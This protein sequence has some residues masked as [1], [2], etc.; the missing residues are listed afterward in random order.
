MTLN[1]SFFVLKYVPIL[2]STYQE[3]RPIT[4][5]IIMRVRI[6]NPK[7]VQYLQLPQNLNGLSA[8]S[9]FANLSFE[10]GSN[11]TE[12]VQLDSFCIDTVRLP[13]SF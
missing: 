12:I 9:L 7:N 6:E 4:Y 13:L 11:L 8:T 1:Y 5:F 10:Y 3:S 2:C